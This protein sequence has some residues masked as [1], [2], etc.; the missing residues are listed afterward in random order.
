MIWRAGTLILMNWR[1]GRC[2]RELRESDNE[3]EE[4]LGT[5]KTDFVE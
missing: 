1:M 3:T 2:G 4:T 5:E